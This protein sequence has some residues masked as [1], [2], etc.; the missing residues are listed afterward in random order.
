M[1][2][3]RANSRLPFRAVEM[4]LYSLF[5]IMVL[6]DSEKVFSGAGAVLASSARSTTDSVAL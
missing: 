2:E 3:L 6:K 1:A 5:W 4:V